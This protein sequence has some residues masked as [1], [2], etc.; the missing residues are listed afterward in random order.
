MSDVDAFAP[1]LPP[2]VV[3][4]VGERLGT[5]AYGGRVVEWYSLGVWRAWRH[6]RLLESH[7]LSTPAL[8]R[9]AALEWLEEAV[10][11]DA[12]RHIAAAKRIK[13]RRLGNE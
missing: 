2:I 9:R 3:E 11:E 4:R 8:A 6:S 13:A 1:P 12:T 5:E 7:R 10:R